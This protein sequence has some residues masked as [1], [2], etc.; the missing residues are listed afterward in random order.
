MA[1]L[2]ASNSRWKTRGA[3]SLWVGGSS[4]HSLMTVTLLYICVDVHVITC[5]MEAW[6]LL[7]HAVY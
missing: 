1:F 3:G 2:A 7:V 6:K 4:V 5:S